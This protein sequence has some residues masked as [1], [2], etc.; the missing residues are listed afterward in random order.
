MA[1]HEGYRAGLGKVSAI[2]RENRPH[3]ARRAI[4]VVSQRLN[5]NRHAAGPIPFVT[6]LVV[7]LGVGTLRLLYSALDVVFGHVLG[8]GCQDRGTQA[9]IKCWIR[10][11]EL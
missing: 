11:A 9:R 2:L 4:P 6:D 8:T 5:D 3:L 7:A 1:E 10:H